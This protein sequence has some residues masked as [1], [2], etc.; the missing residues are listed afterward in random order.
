MSGLATPYGAQTPYTR[1]GLTAAA[2]KTPLFC[3]FEDPE[4]APAAAAAPVPPPPA[5]APLPA[6]PVQSAQAVQVGSKRPTWSEP[7]GAPAAKRPTPRDVAPAADEA[8]LPHPNQE[9][10]GVLLA[11][12]ASAV[13]A[14][15][16]ALQPPVAAT[17]HLHP[18]AP[19]TGVWRPDDELLPPPAAAARPA[20]E[21]TI[22][23]DEPP[24]FASFRPT[25]PTPLATILETSMDGDASF[26]STG[27]SSKSNNSSNRSG[28]HNR[29]YVS[30]FFLY[31][32]SCFRR[33]G[34]F[35]S[36]SFRSTCMELFWCGSARSHPPQA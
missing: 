13:P 4:T 8:P 29:T 14:P 25:A 22:H 3:V 30:P 5:V 28:D 27:S 7:S 10:E 34:S 31:F 32:S 12:P 36:P 33:V 2:T 1:H 20:A 23:E 19:F 17:V 26:V 11:T 21:F 18:T 15:A 24:L 16:R 35:I 6:A 9:N